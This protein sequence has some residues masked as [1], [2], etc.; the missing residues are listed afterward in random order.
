[1]LRK[2]FNRAVQNCSNWRKSTPVVDKN[3]LACTSRPTPQNGADPHPSFRTLKM[4]KLLAAALMAASLMPATAQAETID[5]ATVKCAEL[6]SMDESASTFMFT[7][8]L[9]YQSGAAGTTTMDLSA[10]ESLGTQI[11]EYCGANPD[12]GLLAAST[13]VMSQ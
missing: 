12:V 10:M 5:L 2:R 1:M 13:E 6:A 3:Q 9:G 7:W 8:L 11:G 4:K